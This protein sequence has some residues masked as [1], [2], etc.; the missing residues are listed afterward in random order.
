MTGDRPPVGRM[1]ERRLAPGNEPGAGH[2]RCLQMPGEHLRVVTIHP[3][4]K[5]T[6]GG[7]SATKCLPRTRD[8]SVENIFSGNCQRT[9]DDSVPITFLLA[10]DVN[11]HSTAAEQGIDVVRGDGQ[12]CNG[13]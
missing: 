4:E 6:A 12:R 11:G 2:P 3:D 7:V 10:T 5:P 8:Q 9:E 13:M 1:G